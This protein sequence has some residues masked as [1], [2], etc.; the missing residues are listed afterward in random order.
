[1]DGSYLDGMYYTFKTYSPQLA[2]IS[3]AIINYMNIV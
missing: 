2:Y 1:M 3:N